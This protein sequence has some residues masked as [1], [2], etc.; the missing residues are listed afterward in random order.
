[1]PVLASS[2][3]TLSAIN[4]HLAN[5]IESPPNLH[6]PDYQF[7]PHSHK[8]K[9]LSFV[10]LIIYKIISAFCFAFYFT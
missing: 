5:I 4:C 2:D 6:D 3:E 8:A 10:N 7:C 9:L 1:L